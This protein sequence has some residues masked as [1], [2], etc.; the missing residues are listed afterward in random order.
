MAPSPV[1]V[2][3]VCRHNASIGQ[4]AQSFRNVTPHANASLAAAGITK[5]RTGDA[6]KT[7]TLL[8]CLSLYE[9]KRKEELCIPKTFVTLCTRLHTNGKEKSKTAL[10]QSCI[11]LH[12]PPDHARGTPK[13][14]APAAPRTTLNP[15]QSVTSAHN[16]RASR[17]RK[18]PAQRHPDHTNTTVQYNIFPPQKKSLTSKQQLELLSTQCY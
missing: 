8:D 18:A 13:Q 16:A 6:E 10:S 15:Y 7:M 4:R 17:R 9:R 5:P 12:A 1:V 2:N 11:A 14:T 3:V